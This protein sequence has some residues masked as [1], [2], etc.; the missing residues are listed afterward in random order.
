MSS[1]TDLAW[2]L[3]EELLSPQV[4]RDAAR[5]EDL[6]AP[7]F[8]EIGQSGRQWSRPEMIEALTTAFADLGPTEISERQA[9]ELDGGFVLLTFRLEVAG[10]ASWRS[11]L[12]QVTGYGAHLLFHQGTPISDG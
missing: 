4:R 2:R 3:E 11:S 8:R 9:E 1:D 10:R 12:W 5:L 7:G 6:L